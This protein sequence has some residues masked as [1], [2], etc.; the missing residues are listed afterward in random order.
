[1]YK[2]I[3]LTAQEQLVFNAISSYDLISV[4]EI[5]DLLPGMSEYKINKTCANLASKGYLYRLQKSLYLVQNKPSDVPV[6]KDPYRVALTLYKGY[7]GFSSAL[8][9]YDLLDY[10]PFTIFI[11]TSNMSREKQIGEY[12]FKAVAM[13]KR[14]TGMSYYKGIYTSTLAKTFF[15]CFYKPQYSGG[16]STITK[17]MYESKGLDWREFVGYFDMASD[18]LCQ[19]TGYVLDMLNRETYIVPDQALEYFRSRIKNN[20]RLLPS[21]GGKET[22]SREWMLQDNLGR[23]NILSWW[24]YG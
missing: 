10:E 7:I 18:A 2:N 24:N 8:R 23:E 16:Y 1:M 19:R 17:A 14:A 22:Y 15:D 6:M 5:V 21:G 11:V 4:A 12:V 3:Y 9:I 13:G 20:T